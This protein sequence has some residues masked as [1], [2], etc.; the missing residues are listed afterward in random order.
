M[1]VRRLSEAKQRD[2]ITLAGEMAEMIRQAS[3]QNT[4]HILL[5][6]WPQKLF[7]IFRLWMSGSK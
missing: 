2:T 7:W 4:A 5:R 6:M 3:V 1:Q